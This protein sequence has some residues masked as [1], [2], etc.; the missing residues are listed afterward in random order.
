MGIQYFLKIGYTY[1]YISVK[2]KHLTDILMESAGN[3]D[4]QSLFDTEN[5][6]GS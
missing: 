2:K 1:I 4:I 5:N 6:Q 3:K